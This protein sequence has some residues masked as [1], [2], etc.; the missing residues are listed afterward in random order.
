MQELALINAQ[1]RTNTYF[2]DLLRKYGDRGLAS[3]I[4]I[5]IVASGGWGKTTHKDV[6]IRVD[7]LQPI[8][9]ILKDGMYP[10]L[11]IN[12]KCPKC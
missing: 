2:S 4:C 11:Q 6:D 1:G 5:P 8:F 12:E 10:R 3:N 7:D 9:C